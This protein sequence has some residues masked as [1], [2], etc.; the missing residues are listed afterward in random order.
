MGGVVPIPGPRGL[1]R[2]VDTFPAERWEVAREVTFGPHTRV[3]TPKS[4]LVQ[5]VTHE[6]RHWAQ[7]ATLLRLVG[8]PTGAHDFLLSGVFEGRLGLTS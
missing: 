3:I 6:I 4:M 2:L 8:R 7:L 5:S 1:R